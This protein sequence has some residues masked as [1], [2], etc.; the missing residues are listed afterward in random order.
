MSYEFKLP[1]IGEGVV[2]GEIVGWLVKEGDAV[3]EDQPIVEVLTDKATVV[4]PS[5]KAGTVAKIPWAAGDIVPV[6]DT[7]IVLDGTGD[8]AAPAP[9]A[10]PP[11]PEPTP[12]PEPVHVPPPAPQP[13]HAPVQPPPAPAEPPPAPAQ[14]VAVAAP[15]A[16]RG[17]VLA[18]PSTRRLA[19]E[20]GVDIHTV[21]G[22][23]KAGRVTRED[24]E[25][26]A[27]GSAGPATPAQA[28][29]T[30]V[31]T[32]RVAPA[33]PKLAGERVK[34][35][36]IRRAQANAMVQSF[37]T[38]PHFTFVEEVD[39]T[40]LV[41]LRKRMR[42]LAQAR[43]TDLTYMPFIIKGC[44]IMLKEHPWLNSSLDDEAQEVVF[45]TS[46]NIGIAVATDRGLTVPVI[47]SADTKSLLEV[48]AEVAEK[49]EKAR[50]LKLTPDDVSG[51]SF[52]ITS[53]GKVGG[54]LATP[55]LTPGEVAIVGIHRIFDRPVW[56]DGQ[57]VP[58]KLMYV[59]A[60]FDHR[61]VDG[62]TGATAIQRLRQL[63]ED[64][65]LFLLDLK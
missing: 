16:N 53:L 3:G 11:A 43:G 45:H 7:L 33:T 50:N 51:G 42:P 8:T 31:A 14:Q 57:W 25:R 63:L 28:P 20:L 49:A 59:S 9:V 15:A 24:V 26:A 22:S 13:A 46:Y 54:I 29:V 23:G 48:Q 18:A 34:L 35:R 64:P 2:E 52:T 12:A 10:A 17:R 5:P 60:S 61:V 32:A 47:H 55:I 37:F 21:A 30:A 19:R 56:E 44:A 27:N 62:Y 39:M 1:D 36:G 58:R 65:D 40:N 41:A 38:A 6:G 4:I